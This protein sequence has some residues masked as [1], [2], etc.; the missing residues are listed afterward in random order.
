MAQDCQRSSTLPVEKNA[1]WKLFEFVWPYPVHARE[2]HVGRAVGRVGVKDHRAR[3]TWVQVVPR[4]H[5]RAP[6]L[7]RVT[8]HQCSKH[9]SYWPA[10][11]QSRCC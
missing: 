10:P 7:S 8:G 5:Q 2:R 9:C 6:E 1:N 4:P 11:T 3:R